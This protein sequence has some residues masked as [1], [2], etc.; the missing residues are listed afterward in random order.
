VQ[1]K[2]VTLSGT[3]L[4]QEIYEILIP[5]VDGDIGVF[6]DHEPLVTLARSGVL[7]VRKQKTD[8][9]DHIDLLAISGGIVEI[10]GKNVTIL[11]DEADHGEDIIEAESEKALE[12]A[13]KMRD[14]ANDE[15]ELEKA[16]QLVD[17]HTVRLKV[18]DLRR[19]RR[20]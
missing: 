2:L 3:K 4:D 9:D 7:E 18:A 5:T 6:P 1:L 20:R 13:L 10:D 12:R 16:Q 11:V 17:R 15:I 8:P 14:E 19:R